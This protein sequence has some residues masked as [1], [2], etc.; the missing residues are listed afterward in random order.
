MLAI[1]L[2]AEKN[3]KPKVYGKQEITHFCILLL[4]TQNPDCPSLDS[5]FV[6]MATLHS[7]ILLVSAGSRQL[8]S[9]S[10]DGTSPSP[11]PHP[12]IGDLR[13]TDERI[14]V[15]G[16]SDVRSTIVTES[17]KVATFYDSL[18]RSK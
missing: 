4:F 11:T 14:A 12:L 9:W 15:L 13:L 6:A 1:S 16:S 2:S 7:E 17:G 8:Y 5:K 3:E 18:L 10:C